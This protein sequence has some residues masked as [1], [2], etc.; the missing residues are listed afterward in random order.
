MI[1][2]TIRQCENWKFQTL[3]VVSNSLAE[4]E[5]QNKTVFTI[6]KNKIMS[7]D[8]PDNIHRQG[9]AAQSMPQ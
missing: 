7:L 9:E 5:V 3:A 2:I 6:I 4:L 1:R 8:L